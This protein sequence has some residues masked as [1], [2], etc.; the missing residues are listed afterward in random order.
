MVDLNVTVGFQDDSPSI[1]WGADAN[2]FRGYISEVM[3]FDRALT[4]PE[5]DA[6]AVNY[7]RRRFGLW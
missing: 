1:G 2:Y 6:V 7:L 3:I 5:R 4:D